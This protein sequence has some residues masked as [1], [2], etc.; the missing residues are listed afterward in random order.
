MKQLEGID[1]RLLMRLLAY[2]QVSTATRATA[3][4]ANVVNASI[5][6][7]ARCSDLVV[8]D[9]ASLDAA[10][11][12]VRPSVLPI[13]LQTLNIATTPRTSVID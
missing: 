7:R 1:Q 13:H 4:S 11:M 2:R 3:T 12:M 10:K 8:R 9:L 6:A 5:T